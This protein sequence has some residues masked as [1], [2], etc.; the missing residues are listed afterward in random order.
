YMDLT[1]ALVGPILF[2][3]FVAEFGLGMV[4][5]FAPQMNV[6]FL[7]MGIKSGLSMLFMV[8]YLHF[9]IDFFHLHFFQKNRMG[10]FF[11]SFW[12]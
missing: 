1:F 9:L 5:R 6:F 10:E 2:A 8:L 12:R 4:N 7:S 11:L 3:L